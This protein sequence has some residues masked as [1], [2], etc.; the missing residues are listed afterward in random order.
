MAGGKGTR[1]KNPNLEKPLVKILEKPMITY[2]INAIKN[3]ALISDFWVVTSKY[4]RETRRYV[5]KL[6]CKVINT[7]GESYVKDLRVAA[8]TVP[9][10][11]LIICSSDMPLIKETDLNKII[12][13]YFKHLKGIEALTVVTPLIL[14]KKYRNSIRYVIRIGNFM[15]VPCGINIVNRSKILRGKE[16]KQMY[17]ITNNIRLIINVNTEDDLKIA[18]KYLNVNW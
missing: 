4:T 14:A 3:S 16:L 1:F 17:L 5:E 18:T 15:L 9:Y 12:N 11:H 13:I 6:G 10:N 7:S 8:K 2:V